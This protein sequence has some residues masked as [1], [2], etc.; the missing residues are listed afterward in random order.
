MLSVVIAP[1]QGA[2]VFTRNAQVPHYAA[3]TMKAAVLA[4]LYR[5]DLDWDARVPV[6]N[7]FRSRTGSVYGNDRA[8]DSD[9]LP[10]E[11]L[12]EQVPLRWL[13]ERMVSHSSNLA[14]NL[15]LQ[16]VG[17]PAVA[18]VWRRA[19]AKGG[20]PRGIEDAAARKAGVNNLVSALDLARLLQSLEPEVLAL[21]EHNTHRVDLAAGLPPGVRLA[22]KNG[23][24]TGV[25]LSAALVHPDDAPPY[26][27]S[28]CYTGPLAGGRDVEDPA[29]RLLARISRGVWQRRHT[30]AAAGR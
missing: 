18:E 7:R 29:A 6:V 22:G 5:S 10:W 28:V 12:G 25:R 17:H 30:I 14:T 15:C 1:G 13:A 27:L 24:I 9:P 2:P 23:W 3:S 4:A 20:S 26:V 11:R 16:Q 19:G 8:E 21:L